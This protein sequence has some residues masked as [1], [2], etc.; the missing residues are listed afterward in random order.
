MGV[1]LVKS[2]AWKNLPVKFF[3]EDLAKIALKLPKVES[4]TECV[5]DPTQKVSACYSQRGNELK[6][7]SSVVAAILIQT[8]DGCG[9]IW[10]F[11]FFRKHWFYWE[12][13]S[14]LI[15]YELVSNPFVFYILSFCFCMTQN[16]SYGE[17]G[18]LLSWSFF[19]P[20][21]WN[22]SRFFEAMQSNWKVFGLQCLQ[23]PCLEK[24]SSCRS[25][26]ETNWR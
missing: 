19:V 12:N 9:P 22:K 7:I 5:V 26:K 3:F 14:T 1:A 24:T 11:Y 20:V 6:T 4:S 8:L 23:L 21:P 18:S 17:I 16:W 13:H 10:E 15:V 2:K 25:D